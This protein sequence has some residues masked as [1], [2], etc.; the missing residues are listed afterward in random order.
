MT[1]FLPLYLHA[2]ARLCVCVCVL[3]PQP[4][5]RERE[6][7]QSFDGGSVSPSVSFDLSGR[8]LLFRITASAYVSNTRL[9]ML[10]PSTLTLRHYFRPHFKR[11]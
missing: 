7:F 1:Y 11:W 6:M 3:P 8:L 9:P 10:S 2:A 4:C 5:I